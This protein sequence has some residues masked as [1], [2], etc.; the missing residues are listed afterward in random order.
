MAVSGISGSNRSGSRRQQHLSDIPHSTELVMS[1]IPKK[2]DQDYLLRVPPS[3]DNESQPL[4][5]A[6]TPGQKQEQWTVCSN[7]S[8]CQLL[9]PATRNTLLFYAG[10]IMLSILAAVSFFAFHASFNCLSSTS[11]GAQTIIQFAPPK[12]QNSWGAYS[13]Y[14]PVKS[15]IPPPSHCHITQ[16]RSVYYDY[17][18]PTFRSF[19]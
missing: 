3:S 2:Q 10:A 1:L 18:F 4:L 11:N 15:Y 8:N 12:I 5:I 6:A 16:V 7:Q 13:P 14:F 19:D 9:T 17:C